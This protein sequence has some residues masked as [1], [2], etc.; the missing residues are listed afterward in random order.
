MCGQYIK[1]T[2]RQLIN[3]EDRSPRVSTGDI[4]QKLKVEQ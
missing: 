1:R 2:G 4:K 3:E